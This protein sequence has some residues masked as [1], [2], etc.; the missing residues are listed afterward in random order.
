MMITAVFFYRFAEGFIEKIGPLFLMD[1]RAVGGLGLDNMALGNINGT[2]GTVAFVGG[3]LLGGLL[4]ARYGL[5]RVFVLLAFALNVPHVTFFYL[6]QALPNDLVLI[7]CVVL[8]E[9]LGYGLGTVGMML[10][11]MQELSPGRYRTAH[12]AFATGI[13]ALNMMLTGMVSGRIQAWLGY[14][15][16]FGLVLLASLPPIIIS[17]FAPFGAV[18]EAE[19]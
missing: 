16:F 11:M 9:K 1:K 5:R 2:F 8:I 15:A 3:T 19:A 4:A 17:F 12:Y 7:T 6:S 18:S 10:Y 14:Q 13:M